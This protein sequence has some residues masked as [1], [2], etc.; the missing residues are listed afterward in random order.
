LKAAVVTPTE[1]DAVAP[2][3]I[4]VEDREL[5][6]PFTASN[7]VFDLSDVAFM[8]S[9]VAF[10]EGDVEWTESDVVESRVVILRLVVSDWGMDRY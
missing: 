8:E 2:T 4:G 6:A 3:A 9:E 7:V 10:T 1:Y 5:N